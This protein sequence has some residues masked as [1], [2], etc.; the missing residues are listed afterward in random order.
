MRLVPTGDAVDTPDPSLVTIS[1]VSAISGEKFVVP[2]EQ[3]NSLPLD[4]LGQWRKIPS[5][6]NQ[7]H[8]PGR[9]WSATTGTLLNYESHLELMWLTVLDFEPSIVQIVPQPMYL[10]GPVGARF[11]QHTPDFFVRFD[12]GR[13]CLI[14]VTHPTRADKDRIVAQVAATKECCERIGWEYRQLLDYPKQRWQNLSWLAAYRRAT[15][16]QTHLCERIVPLAR[17]PVRIDDLT[18]FIDHPYLA[19]PALFHLCWNSRVVFDLDQPLRDHTLVIA[20]FP[21]NPHGPSGYAELA[22]HGPLQH[23]FQPRFSDG[24]AT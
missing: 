17:K 14:D 1:A 13:R 5:H 20:T 15:G 23:R 4:E 10:Y 16:I 22:Q 6:A 18:S 21:D 9:Y 3:A 19:R 8:A 11:I 12:D 7:T 24:R 2:L